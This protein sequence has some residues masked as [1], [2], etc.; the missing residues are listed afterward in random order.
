M[1]NLRLPSQLH[2][3]ANYH[4]FKNGIKPMWEDPANA[5]VSTVGR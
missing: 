4:M 5:N 1:N 2:K 3:N